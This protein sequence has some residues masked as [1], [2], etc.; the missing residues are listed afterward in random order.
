MVAQYLV[1][2]SLQDTI[3]LIGLD[4][5]TDRVNL[6]AIKQISDLDLDFK[7]SLLASWLNSEWH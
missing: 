2:S 4:V 6:F 7:L 5:L 3:S 1:A